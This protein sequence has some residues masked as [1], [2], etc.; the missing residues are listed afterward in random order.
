[1]DD[2]QHFPKPHREEPVVGSH[3]LSISIRA[4]L[5]IVLIGTVCAHSLAAIVIAIMTTNDALLKVTEPLY[6][7]SGMALAYYFGQQKGKENKPT[8]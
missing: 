8:P 5:A 1:M 7:M 3:F 2:T 4:W 6:T